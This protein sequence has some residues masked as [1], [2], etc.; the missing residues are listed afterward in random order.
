[1]SNINSSQ[2]K[3]ERMMPEIE[4]QEE[5]NEQMWIDSL[6]NVSAGHRK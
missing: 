2:I 1:M 5:K 6:E 3:A 4:R